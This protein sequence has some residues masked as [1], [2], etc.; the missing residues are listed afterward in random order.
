MLLLT[1]FFPFSEV[2]YSTVVVS[3]WI[4]LQPTENKKTIKNKYFI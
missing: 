2:P 3:G 4:L 1:L